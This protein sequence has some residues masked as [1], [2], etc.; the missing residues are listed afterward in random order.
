MSPSA[1]ALETQGIGGAANPKIMP[2]S[3]SFAEAPASTTIDAKA[4]GDGL[5]QNKSSLPFRPTPQPSFKIEDH[6]IDIVKPLKVCNYL[7]SCFFTVH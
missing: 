1:V 2:S 5:A 6:P 7:K 3:S 4:N